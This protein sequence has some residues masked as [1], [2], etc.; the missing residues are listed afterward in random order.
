LRR[1]N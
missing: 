1:T